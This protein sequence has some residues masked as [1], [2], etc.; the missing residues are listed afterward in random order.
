MEQFGS[1]SGVT[2]Q[3]IEVHPGTSS[4]THGTPG[5]KRAGYP[6]LE[7]GLRI[8]SLKG[9]VAG[10][11]GYS[12]GY[13]AVQGSASQMVAPLLKAAPGDRILDACAAQEARLLI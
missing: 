3:Q 8:S 7:N 11:E 2:S 5:H 10:L 13:F 12:E 1:A 4:G 9:P 6:G